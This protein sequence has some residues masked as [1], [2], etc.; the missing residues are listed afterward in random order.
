MASNE[1]VLVENAV[2]K[3]GISAFLNDHSTNKDSF[4]VIDL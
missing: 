4:G 2:S 1:T 3:L